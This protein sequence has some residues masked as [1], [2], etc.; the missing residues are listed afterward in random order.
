M[1]QGQQC[2][3]TLLANRFRWFSFLLLFEIQTVIGCGVIRPER[4]RRQH[5]FP[6]FVALRTSGDNMA[7]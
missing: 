6:L 2:Y 1:N 4:F 5:S 3:N 7:Q